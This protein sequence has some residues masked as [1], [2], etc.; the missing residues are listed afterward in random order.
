MGESTGQDEILYL[1]IEHILDL[2]ANLLE[3]T[4][5][6]ASDQLRDAGG[7]D[8]ALGRPEQY[9]YY[10][11]ADLALQAAVLAHGIAEGQ[12]FLDG[13]KRLALVAFLLFLAINGFDIQASQE[14]RELWIF[15]LSFGLA[16]TELG[17]RIRAAL[18]PALPG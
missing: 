10:E 18:L 1:H 5:Q 6:E 9:A 11:G 14:E 7:L 8:G 4:L 3:C 15:E 16:P 17:E 2:Y 13:N 12:Y